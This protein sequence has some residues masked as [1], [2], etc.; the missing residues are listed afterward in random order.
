MKNH[1]IESYGKRRRSYNSPK[2]TPK[3]RVPDEVKGFHEKVLRAP[4]GKAIALST[5]RTATE[6]SFT[7]PNNQPNKHL[8]FAYEYRE[9]NEP[10]TCNNRILSTD[11]PRTPYRRRHSDGKS[12]IHWGQ[13]KLLL[14]EIEFLTLYGHLSKTIVYAGAAPG[15]HITKLSEMLTEHKLF[16]MIPM[17]SILN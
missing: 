17:N 14:S 3:K 10:F 9:Y 4:K 15:S 5:P 13:R 11:A 6:K 2:R 16:S 12:V 1:K 7:W 8:R